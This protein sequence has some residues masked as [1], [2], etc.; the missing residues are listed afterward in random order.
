MQSQGVTFI[1]NDVIL[2]IDENKDKNLMLITGPNMGGKSTTL[3]M[4]CIISILA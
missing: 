1:P 4:S 2:G 3:R